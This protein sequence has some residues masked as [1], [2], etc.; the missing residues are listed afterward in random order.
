MLGLVSLS[1]YLIVTCVLSEYLVDLPCQRAIC[2]SLVKPLVS[3]I[4]K[5]RKTEANRL[6]AENN[7]NVPQV[8]RGLL[9]KES[10]NRAI[11]RIPSIR[12]IRQTP[13][14]FSLHT[15]PV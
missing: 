10:V 7:Q 12:A 14:C 5:N 15:S 6:H 4:V 8:C 2:S 1:D 3:F 9:I 13:S 11:L